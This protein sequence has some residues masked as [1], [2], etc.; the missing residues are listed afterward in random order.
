MKNNISPR[1]IF[2]VL[3]IAAGAARAWA[4]DTWLQPRPTRAAT[5]EPV[6]FEMTS[7]AGFIAPET[8]IKPARVSRAFGILAG[9]RFL[10]SDFTLADKTL[11][12]HAN[13]P[14]EGVAVLCVDLKPRLLTLA[15][16]K[17][18]EYLHEIHAGPGLRETWNAIPTPRQWRENYI[19]HAKTFV[20]V[21]T[22]AALNR[23][24]AI[25]LGA[26]LEIVPERDPTTL[27]PGE[28]LAV[29]VLRSGV[30]FPGFNL[31]FVSAGEKQE[32]VVTTDAAGRA[33]ARLDAVGAWMIHG[34][35]L[36]RSLE[37]DLEWESDFVTMVVETR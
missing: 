28:E 26:A 17:I 20:R 1:S 33:Q 36:R 22:P 32:H 2:L 34:T 16:D 6:A 5:G 27:R 12:L 29:R 21:G 9:E 14:R 37:T 35:D 25:P 15:P 23:D 7:A 8:A 30:P 10:L 24:W 19:K 11:V 18:E 4:H 13:F 3:A 31:G